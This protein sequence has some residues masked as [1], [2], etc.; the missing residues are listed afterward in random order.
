MGKKTVVKGEGIQLK[1]YFRLFVERSVSAA[2][3][4]NFESRCKTISPAYHIDYPFCFHP[5]RDDYHLCPPLQQKKHCRPRSNA[6]AGPLSHWTNDSHFWF[7]VAFKKWISLFEVF[8]SLRTECNCGSI[9]V[10]SEVGVVL[11]HI[12]S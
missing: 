3:Q 4:R 12:L 11:V 1:V 8:D 6:L 7:E 2:S 5:P 9:P 10:Y